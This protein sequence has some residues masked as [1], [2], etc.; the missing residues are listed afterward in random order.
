MRLELWVNNI[1]IVYTVW[2]QGQFISMPFKEDPGF[3]DVGKLPNIN[4]IC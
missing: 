4:P 1:F 2:S 3:K